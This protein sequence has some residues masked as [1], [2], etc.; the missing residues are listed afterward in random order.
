MAIGDNFGHSS[1]HFNPIMRDVESGRFLDE[2]V[3]LFASR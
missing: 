2:H 3:R 1:G